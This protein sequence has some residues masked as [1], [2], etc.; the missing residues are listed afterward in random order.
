MTT[1]AVKENDAN[2]TGNVE[3]SKIELDGHAEDIKRVIEK[4]SSSIK[5]RITNV[6]S[7]VIDMRRTYLTSEHLVSALIFAVVIISLIM[8]MF[9]TIQSKHMNESMSK[10]MHNTT[11]VMMKDIDKL[12]D[13]KIDTI[14]MKFFG[15]FNMLIIPMFFTAFG[16]IFT[17]VCQRCFR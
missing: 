3:V 12:I 15:H 16:T 6:E 2:K 7:N 8:L 1:D 9:F 4:E 14:M 13:A 10:E 17:L 5:C 11:V